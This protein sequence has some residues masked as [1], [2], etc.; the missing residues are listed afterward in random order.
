MDHRYFVAV[1]GLD[2][3]GKTTL[4]RSLAEWAAARLAGPPTLGEGSTFQ[5]RALWTYEPHN[6]YAAGSYIRHVLARELKATPYMLMLAY[7]LNRL[8]HTHTL[9]APFLDT[10]DS[11]P[12]MVVSD[13]YYLSSLA[14][15]ASAGQ[16]IEAV[17]AVNAHARRPDLHLFLDVDAETG[18]ARLRERGGV[19]ELFDERLAEMRGRYEAAIAFLRARGEAVAVI[20]ARAPA[21]AVFAAAAEA[22]TAAAPP[23]VRARLTGVA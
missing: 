22:V 14:Y 10:D 1:E 12:R 23:R 5:P 13:R 11:A 2:G 9:I 17:M 15:Q 19:L 16:P 8:D 18:R 21:E 3:S 4:S 7:A 20:D 6:A